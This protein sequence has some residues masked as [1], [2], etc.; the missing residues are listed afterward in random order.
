MIAIAGTMP[1]AVRKGPWEVD[2][3]FG[4]FSKGEH[5]LVNGTC[6]YVKVGDESI[7]MWFLSGN[8]LI[9][10][11]QDLGSAKCLMYLKA[12]RNGPANIEDAKG[13]WQAGD[14]TGWVDVPDVRVIR[15]QELPD[16]PEVAVVGER[17]REQRDAEGRKGAIDL[18]GETPPR[19]R[20]KA[21]LETRVVKARSLC[22]AAV[23]ARVQELLKP[24]FEEYTK[25]KIDE[26]ELKRRKA[27]AREE[28]AAGHAPL[29]KLDQAFADYDA[30]M[31][32]GDAAEAK[33]EAALAELERG[34]AGPSG[35]RAESTSES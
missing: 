6:S 12:T 32:A 21:G 11:G 28:A 26:A 3:A 24:V 19:K 15:V 8:W 1:E 33:L 23:D 13:M 18:D 35:V 5:L 31:K 17:T 16:E 22:Q 10:P 34:Q 20:S 30:A 4:M 2:L 25:D 27:A 9:G 14:G 7:K 29:T